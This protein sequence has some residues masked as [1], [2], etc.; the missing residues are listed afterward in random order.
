MKRHQLLL[1]AVL[2]SSLIA[3]AQ[4]APS[5]LDYTYGYWA[6]TWRRDPGLLDPALL[7]IESGY[8]GFQWNIKNPSKI[9]FGSLDDKVGYL[10]AGGMALER[11]RNLPEGKLEAE[12]K[13][14]GR[15]YKMTHQPQMRA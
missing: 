12:V 5:P 1:A 13:I 9:H 8:Y 11:L 15:A 3:S 14:V 7:C 10:Q 2:A 4:P 6:G